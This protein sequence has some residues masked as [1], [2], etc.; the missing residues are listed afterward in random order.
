[1]SPMSGFDGVN[2]N[3][4]KWLGSG[5]LIT[6]NSLFFWIVSTRYKQGILKKA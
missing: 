4:Q 6:D 2:L 1:M 3:M 5:C